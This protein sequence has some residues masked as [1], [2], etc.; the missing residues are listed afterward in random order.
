MKVTTIIKRKM[1]I[2]LYFRWKYGEFPCKTPIFRFVLPLHFIK[3]KTLIT[4]FDNSYL[5]IHAIPKCQNRKIAA[6]FHVK[7]YWADI[8]I[9]GFL[10]FLLL[11]CFLCLFCPRS[12]IVYQLLTKNWQNFKK[13]IMMVVCAESFSCP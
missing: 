3:R 7:T 1:A 10:K 5:I 9:L 13:K 2:T 6:A 12:Y 11:I 4:K 8:F